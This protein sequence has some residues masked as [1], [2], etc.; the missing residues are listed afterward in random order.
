MVPPTIFK[1][2]RRMRLSNVKDKFIVWLLIT[3]LFLVDARALGLILMPRSRILLKNF[4]RQFIGAMIVK[5]GW[6]RIGQAKF[7]RPDVA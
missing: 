2:S 5:T 6:P 7:N 3:A 1:V 4:S